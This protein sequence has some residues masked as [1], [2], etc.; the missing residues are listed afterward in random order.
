MYAESIANHNR[1]IALTLIRRALDTNHDGTLEPRERAAA[2]IVLFGQSWGGAAAIATAR[3]LEKLGVPVLLTAQIDSV[4]M[5][6]AVV[7]R[8][9]RA[10]VNFY[11]HDPFTI[12]GRGGIRAADPHRT[13]ILGNFKSS[14]AGRRMDE[15][16]A[17]W[18]RRVFGR[19]HTKM[20]LDPVIWGE[21]E[22]CILDAIARRKP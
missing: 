19:S 20:E 22:S 17:S 11:Q 16:N 8:N 2:Q 13:K 3:E 5:H 9:V 12:R 15:S 10:A 4:G 1:E 7:P 14:Y 21:V 6:D 18:Q